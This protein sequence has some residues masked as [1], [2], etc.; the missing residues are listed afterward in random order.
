MICDF[1]NVS[2]LFI[3]GVFLNIEKS[4]GKLFRRVSDSIP[5]SLPISIPIS[6]FTTISFLVFILLFSLSLSA[7]VVCVCERWLKMVRVVAKRVG[8]YFLSTKEHLFLL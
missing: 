3:S 4:T 1:F 5:I 2:Q 6:F 7:A 8:Y